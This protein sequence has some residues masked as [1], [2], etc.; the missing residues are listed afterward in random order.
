MNQNMI[1]ASSHGNHY[2]Y[3]PGEKP[4]SSLGTP[5]NALQNDNATLQNNDNMANTAQPVGV[6]DRVPFEP[7]SVKPV[8]TEDENHSTVHE[9]NIFGKNKGKKKEFNETERREAQEA[10][11]INLKGVFAGC[12]IIVVMIIV[13]SIAMFFI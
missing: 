5:N 9:H 1:N 12:I 8:K 2:G 6:K 4:V 11:S 3:T 13:V 7:Y 10:S